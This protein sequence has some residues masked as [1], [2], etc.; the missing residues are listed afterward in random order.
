MMSRTK[1]IF[2]CTLL[3]MQQE[4]LFLFLKFY[5]RSS[6]PSINFFSDEDKE[7]LSAPRKIAAGTNP[8]SN[9]TDRNGLGNL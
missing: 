5:F 9:D 1:E 2:T 3:S 4:S 8:A 7:G 6:L